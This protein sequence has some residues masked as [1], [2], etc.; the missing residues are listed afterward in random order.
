MMRRLPSLIVFAVVAALYLSGGLVFIENQLTEWR[1]RLTDRNASGDLVLVEID[2]NSLNDIDVWPWPRGLYA[3]ALEKLLDAGANRIAINID[4]SSPSLPAEDNMLLRALS[5]SNGQVILPVFKQFTEGAKGE[6]SLTLSR[7]IAQFSEQAQLAFINVQPGTDGVTRRMKVSEGWE[8]QALPSLPFALIGETDFAYDAFY[9]DYGIRKASIP[10]ISFVDILRGEFDSSTVAGKQVIVG[11]TAVQLGNQLAVPVYRVASGTHVQALAYESLAQGRTLLLVPPVAILGVTFFLVLFLGSRFNDWSWRRGLVVVL[12]TCGA[13]WPLTL[14]VQAV[15]PVL[16]DITPLMLAISLSYAVAVVRSIDQQGVRLMLQGVEIQRR[17]VMMRNVAENSF[18]GIIVM[19]DQG[20]IQSA[21]PAVTNMFKC[22]DDEAVGRHIS[23]L[24]QGV[25]EGARG[26]ELS[27]FFSVGEKPQELT[28][29]SFA[30]HAFPVEATVTKVEEDEHQLLVAFVRD[31]SEQKQI[32]EELRKAH[33][34]LED[35]V[36]ERTHQ[37]MHEVKERAHTAQQ[38]R[39]SEERFRDI[40]ES[41]SDWFW[42]MGPDLKFSYL[43]DSFHDITGIDPGSIIGKTRLQLSADSEDI[44]G[45]DKAKWAEHQTVLENRRPFRNFQYAIRRQ[46]GADIFVSISGKPIFDTDGEFKGYRGSGTNITEKRLSERKLSKT[47]NELQGILSTTSQGYWRIDGEGQIVEVNPRMAEILS[48]SPS[49][50][51]GTSVYDYLSDDQKAYFR[52]KLEKRVVGQSKE[53]DLVLVNADGKK[54]PCI[55]SAT[56]FYDEAGNEDGSFAL[57]SDITERL[58]ADAELMQTR[59]MEALGRVA[60]GIAHNFNN[61]LQPI[62]LL[63]QVSLKESE[64]DGPMHERL[65]HI[66]EATLRSKELIEQVMTYSRESNP[67]RHPIDAAEVFQKTMSLIR[68]SL[69]TTIELAHSQQCGACIINANESQIQSLIMNI[70]GNAADAIG[71]Q[72]GKIDVVLSRC[73]IRDEPPQEP[74]K[75]PPG[76]YVKLAVKDT[77]HGMDEETLAHIFDPFYTTKEVGSGTGL[78]LASVWGIVKNHDGYIFPTSKPGEGTLI[79][80]F[81]PIVEQRNGERSAT[82]VR[83]ERRDGGRDGA[84]VAK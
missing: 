57:V 60:G 41:S 14:A 27:V 10:R 68:L 26:N 49:E 55:I 33:Y 59:K 71:M 29:R 19:D 23:M 16:V 61:M 65:Q 62:L 51:V 32:E 56:P 58:E 6:R 69:P 7:P 47:A 46:D 8:G 9:I 52:N 45:E 77:G 73:V 70:T 80:V 67:V 40:A 76:S 83:D 11:A 36:L 18:D 31:I 12:L 5:R 35:R 30:G 78:G 28:G 37:L 21:N 39:A 4:F 72:V 38:L 42:E 34:E 1:F 20:V 53:Y 25:R 3:V 44:D 66:E 43:T 75:L 81:L 17:D 22:R 24:F 74:S 64:T 13:L 79:E 2:P 82:Q 15:T 63:T 50:A 48:V 84:V 54:V